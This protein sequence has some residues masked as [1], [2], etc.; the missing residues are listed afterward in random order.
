MADHAQA[1]RAYVVGSFEHTPP[2]LLDD[3]SAGK[4]SLLGIVRSMGE[5]L[6]SQDEQQRTRAVQ[7]L[8]E[9]T[10]HFLDPARPAPTPS[11]PHSAA[12]SPARIAVADIFTIQ[13]V[14][15]LTTFLAD[16][17]SD[18][19]L[20]FDS[21]IRSANAP[22]VLPETA[23]RARRNEAEAK[24][25]QG[26][27]ML[28]SCLRALTAL[29][30]CH[31][32]QPPPTQPS[33][34]APVKG[35]GLEQAHAVCTALFQH[36]KPSDHPQSLRFLVYRLLDSLVAHHRNS[37]K[38]YRDPN[39]HSTG[40]GPTAMDLDKQQRGDDDAEDDDDE[41]DDIKKKLPAEARPDRCEGKPFLKG[42]V[43]LVTGEK[44]PRNLMVL[45]GVD[46]V[47][48]TEWQMDREMTEAFFDITFCYFPITFRPPPDDPY[49]ITSDDL[50]LALRAALCASPA[51]APLG[52]PLLLE[53]LSAAGGPAKLDTL[54]TIIA[55]APVYGRAAADANAKRLWEGLKIEIFHATD[56]E[57]CDLSCDALTTLLHVLYDGID[58]PQGIAPRM[59]HDCLVEL[60]EPGKSLAK[61]AIKVLGCM[62]RASPSTAYLATYGFMD[63]MMKMFAE[64]ADLAMRTPILNGVGEVLEAL[65]RVYRASEAVQASK[66][67]DRAETAAASPAA[68]TVPKTDATAAN[69]ASFRE[70]SG[71]M[72][73][74]KDLRRS[75]QGDNRPLDAFLGD[76]LS[77]LSN[78]LRSTSYRRSALMAYSSVV[79]I[80]ILST[81]TATAPAAPTA[82][83][84]ARPKP[85]LSAD[86]TAF[87]TR[88]VA[89]L[90]TSVKGDDVREEALCAIE[91]VA[92][93]RAAGGP[94]GKSATS[95]LIEEIVLPVLLEGLPER[96]LPSQDPESRTAGQPVDE[97]EG[98]LDQS[99][100]SIRRS[101]GAISHLCVAPH[102][103]DA[104]VVKLFTRLELCCVPISR[105]AGILG[106][107]DTTEED[108][109]LEAIEEE[110]RALEEANLGYARGLI[111][112]LQ[113]LLDEK[114][115]RGHRD[116]AKYG[117]ALPPRLVVLAL[118]GLEAAAEA[119]VESSSPRRLGIGAHAQIIA[120]S[121][122][123][124][125][126]LVKALDT[127]KQRELLVILNKTF[128][129]GAKPIPVGGAD[130]G[131]N[132]ASLIPSNSP[133]GNGNF[134]PFDV[135]DNASSFSKAKR[136]SLALFSA[137]VVASGKEAGIPS[138]GDASSGGDGSAALA[139]VRQLLRWTLNSGV[140]ELQA[141]AGMWMLC[142]CINKHVDDT[143]AAVAAEFESLADELWRTEV[144]PVS[145]GDAAPDPVRRRRAQ[146]AWMWMARGFS[147][148]ASKQGD[149]MIG[150]VLDE[151]FDAPAGDA[152]RADDKDPRWAAAKHA[153]RSLEIVARTEDGVV[154]K[155]N[156]FTIRLLSRQRFFSSL[157]PRLIR[158]NGSGSAWTKTLYL[159]ALSSLLP[160]LPPQTI[161]DQLVELFPL[162]IQALSL[163]DARA[164]MSAADGILVSVEVGRRLRAAPAS[165]SATALGGSGSA[166]SKDP[167][168]LVVSH[169]STLVRRL[170]ENA[171]EARHVV[172]TTRIAAL[173]ALSSIAT[174][175]PAAEVQRYKV[176]VLKALAAPGT[177]IDDP[178][179]KVR[180]RAVDCRDAWFEVG[181]A[182]Q[183]E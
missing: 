15:T 177:G 4:V 127:A 26:S 158:G 100:A 81:S 23:P 64:P 150:R 110:V 59:V 9:I 93:E 167:T 143:Q 66:D 76:L 181:S 10:C 35:F 144:L 152:A 169:L 101:L 157:L 135:E 183:D 94:A 70:G 137:A 102:L 17:V 111:L 108:K 57:T 74:A 155:A 60:E 25:L 160:Y 84:D 170:L 113:T 34:A 130:G 69:D 7:L 161:S 114:K 131:N 32:S 22:E 63:Q 18:S 179:R 175:L 19:V 39:S 83:D 154:T 46:K 55:A 99:K 5:Y 8:A 13:A 92:N 24:T 182:K 53:K 40:D 68:L 37:L 21:F 116:L 104:V 45:F 146:Q 128:S 89:E 78:G 140:S 31:S 42:Y 12:A 123:L 180:E 141:Q 172:A 95:K 6:T 30:A 91:V 61:A 174:A 166:T 29:S 28:V 58:P 138:L 36:V 120:D 112:T 20:I 129:G 79:A 132:G 106:V 43:R 156:G 126:T 88:E 149:R 86:E 38:S 41:D 85:F 145:S 11:V 98:L 153:S 147:V 27:A 139:F 96:M 54:R 103:F 80:S 171:R 47:L 168:D 67:R 1:I 142:S 115:R 159:I 90:L 134:R 119:D 14:R 44:D 16:K 124:L 163:P 65:A 136:D 176:E 109:P 87:L 133:L 3:L 173:R 125:G 50:K 107:D 56:D 73:P 62:V 118:S 82:S 151:I 2:S 97:L 122:R 148:K 178:K 48:L 77:S 72:L 117:Q 164:R 51:M 75:Y 105:S 165:A 71:Q 121:A 33:Q 52:Y 162:L 49:G